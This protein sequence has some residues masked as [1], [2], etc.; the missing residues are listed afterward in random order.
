M[1][2][3]RNGN[4]RVMGSWEGA[5]ILEKFIALRTRGSAAIL[6]AHVMTMGLEN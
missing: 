4:I 1:W 5:E 3:G 2:R 6:A